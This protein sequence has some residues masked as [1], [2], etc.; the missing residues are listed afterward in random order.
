MTES[1]DM[2]VC[3]K[4]GGKNPPDSRFCGYCGTGIPQESEE[5]KGIIPEVAEPAE[6]DRTEAAGSARTGRAP[7]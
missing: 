7:D 1:M 6:A 4:C 3:P 5:K 2:A